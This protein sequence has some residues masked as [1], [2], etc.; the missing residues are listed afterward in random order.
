MHPDVESTVQKRHGP[1]GAHPEEGHK[2]Q[3]LKGT[4]LLQEQAE[5]SGTVQAGE[6]RALR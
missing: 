4:S 1:V 3:P 2:S 5:R 6:E